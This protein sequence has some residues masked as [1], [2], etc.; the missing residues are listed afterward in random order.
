[1]CGSLFNRIR[2]F[3]Q[4]Y[5]SWTHEKHEKVFWITCNKNHKQIAFISLDIKWERW[6]FIQ[7]NWKNWIKL[8]HLMSQFID[9]IWSIRN[10]FLTEPS[11]EYASFNYFATYLIWSFIKVISKTVLH[12]FRIKITAEQ[13]KVSYNLFIYIKFIYFIRDTELTRL[14]NLFIM[15]TPYIYLFFFKQVVILVFKCA[16]YFKIYY[17]WDSYQTQIETL[18]LIEKNCA[19]LI[20]ALYLKS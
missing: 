10:F 18:Y 5:L 7:L 9:M 15:L 13:V 12:A 11:P 20:K 19:I 17:V 1:M 8:P 6:S 2:S 14:L 16:S 3:K 4:Y